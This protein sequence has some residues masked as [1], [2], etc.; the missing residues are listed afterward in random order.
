MPCGRVNLARAIE[1]K[2]G[3]GTVVPHGR[4]ASSASPGTRY[5]VITP[6]VSENAAD[7]AAQ[8]VGRLAIT[9]DRGGAVKGP[10][11]LGRLRDAVN[12]EIREALRFRENA[13]AS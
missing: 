8:P 5:S 13:A 7:E 6:S 9:P 2:A 3:R 1:I 10:P 11:D 12:G 4:I